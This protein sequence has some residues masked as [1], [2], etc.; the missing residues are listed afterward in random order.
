[1]LVLDTL[2][3]EGRVWYG[4]C[5]PFWWFNG[6]RER[7]IKGVVGSRCW[8]ICYLS[9]LCCIRLISYEQQRAGIRQTHLVQVICCFAALTIPLSNGP[10]LFLRRLSVAVE[11]YKIL[12][13]TRRRHAETKVRRYRYTRSLNAVESILDGDDGRVR[14]LARWRRLCRRGHLGGAALQA[15]GS[16][17][18]G[19]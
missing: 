18:G 13:T 7:G 12:Q 11:A 6:L 17:T 2:L 15:I 4:G 10:I 1:M 3:A 8:G 5:R 9:I 16:G 14:S 19:Q